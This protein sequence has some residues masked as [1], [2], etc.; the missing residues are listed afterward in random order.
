MEKSVQLHD[1][2]A[3]DLAETAVVTR[4]LEDGMGLKAYGRLEER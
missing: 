4:S 3:L 1:P 2:T